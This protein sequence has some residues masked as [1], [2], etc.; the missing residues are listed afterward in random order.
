MGVFLQYAYQGAQYAKI[1]ITFSQ[2]LGS[3]SMFSVRWPAG[4]LVIVG[5]VKSIRFDFIQL[6]GLSC[7]WHGIS[8][9]GTLTAYTIGPLIIFLALLLPVVVSFVMG[10][11][12]HDPSRW[13]RT[14]DGF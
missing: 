8:F 3:F 1:I 5:W 4:L 11:R 6:P 14:L 12:K 7:L 10:Q 9:R 13:S 2:I